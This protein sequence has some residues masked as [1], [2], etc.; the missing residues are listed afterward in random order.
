[1]LF[2]EP[3]VAIRAILA[4]CSPGIQARKLYSQDSGL[5]GVQT[6]IAAEDI[7]VV[8]LLA[9]VH[10]K[11]LEALRHSRVV[12]GHQATVARAAQVFRGEEAEASE[13]A[14]GADETTRCSGT[15]WPA[16]RLQ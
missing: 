10:A 1:M 7:V 14:K 3:A 8:L 16:R 11:H 4:A 6:A 9:A 13:M 12:G 15:R 2:E 5:Q